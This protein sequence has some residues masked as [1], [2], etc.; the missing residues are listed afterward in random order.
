MA[1]RTTGS[2]CLKPGDASIRAGSLPSCATG[3]DGS[4]SITET[5]SAVESGSQ[6]LKSVVR[7]ARGSRERVICGGSEMFRDL[8]IFSVM[9]GSL[10]YKC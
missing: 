4:D 3:G 8:V 7:I 10:D 2:T 9:A 5:R 1:S 6:A